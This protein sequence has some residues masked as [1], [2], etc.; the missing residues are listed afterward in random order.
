MIAANVAL[1]GTARTAPPAES[2]GPCEIFIPQGAGAEQ[3]TKAIK[4]RLEADP[5]A[6]QD[7]EITLVFAGR[8]PAGS[9]G[10]FEAVATRHG[11]SIVGLRSD[12]DG[13]GAP[14]KGAGGALPVESYFN[15]DRHSRYQ[16]D[17]DGHYRYNE[18]PLLVPGPL[19]SGAE[20]YSPRHVVI[21]GDVNPGAEVRA[22]GNIVVLGS[23][24]GIAHAGCGNED[25]FIVALHLDPQQLRI[26]SL[27]ARA[28]TS[29]RTPTATEIAY[30]A[31]G[32]IIVEPYQGRLPH[33]LAA[34]TF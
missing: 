12:D 24:R 26:G 20:I 25:S 1:R 34:A 7:A 18:G 2:A 8:P 10:T 9:L 30:A 15:Q 21:V 27:I 29:E 11:L 33:R 22:E 3:L 5:E 32:G 14:V 28:D 17:A 23:L 4:T 31:D 16:R 13:T 19:R 6:F